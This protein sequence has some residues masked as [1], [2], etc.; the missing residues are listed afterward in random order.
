MSLRFAIVIAS[1]RGL[2]FAQR[3]LESIAWQQDH[4]VEQVVYVDDASG[5]SDSEVAKLRSLLAPV[6]GELV[7]NERRLWQARSLARGLA[8]IVDPGL[9]VCLLDG[10]DWLLPHALRTV[11]TAYQ[12]P[13]VALTWGNTLVDFRPFQNP[14]PS[15]FGPDKRT[16]NTPYPR[17]VWEGRS[18]RSDGFRCFHLRTFRRWLWEF[19]RAEDLRL[20]SGEPIRGSGD[21]AVM[22]PLLELLGNHRHVYFI[23]EPIYVYRLHDEQVH[24]LDKPG[25]HEALETLRFQMPPYEPIDRLLLHRLLQEHS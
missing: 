14:Q 25:Q 8:Q 23:E 17:A 9:V 15:Y 12:D 4:S 21:S 5:Y 16:V 10:D 24:H 19:V 2:R 22:F 1:R 6:R 3:C 11:A 20:P 7:V 18:F 13:T